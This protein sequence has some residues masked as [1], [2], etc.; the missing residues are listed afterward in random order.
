MS[1]RALMFVAS[2]AIAAPLA[3]QDAAVIDPGMTRAEVV[4]R[5]G[6]PLNERKSGGHTYLYYRNGCEKTCGMN[7]VVML[8]D[9][10]VSDAI[11]RSSSR[12]YSGES[13]SPSGVH[14]SRSEPGDAGVAAVR[15]AKRGGIVIA[16][17]ADDAAPATVTGVQVVPA[18]GGAPDATPA[19]APRKAAVRNNE[20]SNPASRPAAQETGTGSSGIGTGGSGTAGGNAPQ[21]T[22]PGGNAPQIGS[23]QPMASPTA[24]ANASGQRPIMPVPLPGAKI[25]PADSVRALTPNRPTPM[26]GAKINPAD[27]IRAEAIRRQ[28][29][30]TTNKP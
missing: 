22:T 17:P 13:S 7:D 12:H 15:K 16:R 11:F 24:P 23:P 25:N 8:D 4:E 20:A 28:Q 9:G 2:L 10:K 29:A 19:A 21:V 3:A 26:P 30:D 14:A 5:L 18:D 1:Y 27:S 6:K